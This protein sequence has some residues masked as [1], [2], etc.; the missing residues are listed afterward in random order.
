MQGIVINFI[1]FQIGWFACVLGAANDMPWLG[2]LIAIPIVFWHLSQASNKQQEIRLIILALAIGPILDQALLTFGFSV[3]PQHDIASLILPSWMLALWVIF[4]TTLNVSLRWMRG[5]TLVAIIFGAVGGPLAYLG[6]SKL[7]AIQFNH[8][9]TSMLLLS[10][11]W[12]MI[13]P[14]LLM[15]SIKFDGYLT[16]IK[17]LDNV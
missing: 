2:A 17:G 14:L 13:T 1:A 16:D 6:A 10:I 11:G 9:N 5:K 7:G 8:F 4:A 12:A 3:F 15:L